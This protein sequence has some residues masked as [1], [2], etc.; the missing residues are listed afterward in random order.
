MIKET[1]VYNG[2]VMWIKHHSGE[3][4]E[5][6]SRTIWASTWDNEWWGW[7]FDGIGYSGKEGEVIT[8]SFENISS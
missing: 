3:I 2:V 1:A 4:D 7:V 5:S 8:V 6:Y